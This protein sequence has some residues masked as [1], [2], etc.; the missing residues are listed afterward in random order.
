MITSSRRR[1]GRTSSSI[2]AQ[3]DKCLVWLENSYHVATLDND[4]EFIAGEAL[5]FIQ[6]LQLKLC[7]AFC[8]HQRR[9]TATMVMSS[10]CSQPGLVN[11]VSFSIR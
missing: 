4:K 6:P 1:M 9:R 3:A 5:K 2:S 7:S 10:S 11:S 8:E